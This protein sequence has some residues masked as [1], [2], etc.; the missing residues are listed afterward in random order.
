MSKRG[1]VGNSPASVAQSKSPP[2][3]QPKI[4]MQD[5][6]VNMASRLQKLEMICS[7]KF[8]GLET[9]I[10]DHETKFIEGTPDLDKFAEMISN[11]NSRLNEMNER[12]SNLEKTNN[13]KAPK[14]K[15]G[16]VMLTEL[17]GNDVSFTSS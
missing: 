6:V 13:V 2:S 11:L 8:K 4:S 9:K 15:G 12:L 3:V 14:K 16:T 10:G 1:P 5:A 7:T 17:E